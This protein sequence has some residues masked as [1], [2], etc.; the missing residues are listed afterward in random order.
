MM[1]E[2]YVVTPATIQAEVYCFSTLCHLLA[3]IFTFG[4]NIW[5][6]WSCQ[7]QKPTVCSVAKA[8]NWNKRSHLETMQ[9][10]NLPL[11]ASEKGTDCNKLHIC[12]NTQQTGTA[13]WLS[14]KQE[15]LNEGALC[16]LATWRRDRYS[17]VSMW[18]KQL[19]SRPPGSPMPRS[20]PQSLHW[21]AGICECLFLVTRSLLNIISWLDL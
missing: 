2:I 16:S 13:R 6:I 20:W 9:T 11:P 5:G 14:S 17:V 15:E 12:A 10:S 4:L 18:Q 8:K 3:G 7:I 19:C 1:R 21:P